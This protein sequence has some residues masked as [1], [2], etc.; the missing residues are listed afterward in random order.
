LE[1]VFIE[2]EGETLSLVELEP[3]QKRIIPGGGECGEDGILLGG[4]G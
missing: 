3:A 1:V 4:G 2:Q